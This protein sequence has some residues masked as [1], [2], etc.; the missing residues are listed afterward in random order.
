MAH[1]TVISGVS[2]RRRWSVAERCEILTL[3]SESGAVIADIARRAD[4]STSLIYKWRQEERAAAT[5]T[6]GFAPAVLVESLADGAPLRC[7][8]TR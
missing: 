8:S 2:R 1:M 4:V 3:V 5:A 7:A 6:V